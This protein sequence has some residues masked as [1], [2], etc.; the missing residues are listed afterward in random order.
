MKNDNKVKAYVPFVLSEAD[1]MLLD[2]YSPELSVS[3]HAA[4]GAILYKNGM[5]VINYPVT[6]RECLHRPLSSPT[7][8]VQGRMFCGAERLDDKWNK[9]G[10][11]SL[12]ACIAS[13]G[14]ATIRQEMAEM[15]TVVRFE[16]A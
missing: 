6:I 1:L 10:C 14:D 9:T 13:M 8:V 16:E 5:D 15:A 12:E 3:G 2:G 11:M 4:L 7:K